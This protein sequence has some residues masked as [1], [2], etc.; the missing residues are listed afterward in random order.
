M[1]DGYGA[2]R[3][4]SKA[5]NLDELLGNEGAQSASTAMQRADAATTFMRTY[6]VD[7]LLLAVADV[8]IA[9]RHERKGHSKRAKYRLVSAG[10]HIAAASEK[11][12]RNVV[13]PRAAERAAQAR[14]E[15]IL[16]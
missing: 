1:A 5:T 14:I 9:R 11:L 4:A 12:N 13:A 3:P 2:G 15:R 6:G 7:H 16:S 10:M 8:L